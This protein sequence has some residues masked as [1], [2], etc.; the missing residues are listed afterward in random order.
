MR[1]EGCRGN[2]EGRPGAVVLFARGFEPGAALLGIG[3]DG[4]LAFGDGDV[5][6]G[7]LALFRQ[8]AQRTIYLGAAA[9]L[10]DAGILGLIGGAQGA[11]FGIGGIGDRA[12]GGD[13]GGG[14]GGKLLL[15]FGLPCLGSGNGLAKA[16]AG[17]RAVRSGSPPPAGPLRPHLR[18]ARRNRPSGAAHRRG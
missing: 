5:L 10:A 12:F 14:V 16:E 2:L 13:E 7:G 9:F 1:G 18:R 17:R 11:A 15:Y 6:F 4:A 8:I 3:Q